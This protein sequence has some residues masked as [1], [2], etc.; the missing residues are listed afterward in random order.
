MD[1]QTD[2]AQEKTQ[3]RYSRLDIL[4][5]C[6]YHVTLRATVIYDVL[7]LFGTRCIFFVQCILCSVR[8]IGENDV[9]HCC[10]RL[11]ACTYSRCVRKITREIYRER[12]K[13]SSSNKLRGE[14]RTGDDETREIRHRR[15]KAL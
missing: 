4:S 10:S 3:Q 1:E 9:T 6:F 15:G 8:V 2:S 7:D 5:I 14:E 12:E 11:R 13:G